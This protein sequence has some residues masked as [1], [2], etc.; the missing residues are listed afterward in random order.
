[1]RYN[2]WLDKDG[3]IHLH[4]FPK[5]DQSENRNFY[6]GLLSVKYDSRPRIFYGKNGM[7]KNNSNSEL[8]S[9]VSHDEITGM[10]LIR[11]NSGLPCDDLPILKWNNRWWLHPRDMSFYFYCHHPILGLPFLWITSLC[12]IVSCAQTYKVRNGNKIIKTD[13]KLSAWGK[14]QTY[15]MRLTYKICTWL[16]ERNPVFGSWNNCAKIYFKNKEHPLRDLIR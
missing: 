15:D 10:Y 8:G 1:M 9:H 3:F 13:G 11:K 7:F 6:T 16:I 12:M 14:C 2:D 5:V 4:K